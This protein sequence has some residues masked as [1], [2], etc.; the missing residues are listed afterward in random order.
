MA[1]PTEQPASS[2][3]W[4]RELR[5][6]IFRLERNQ[7]KTAA[8]RRA[9]T[10]ATGEVI[11]VQDADLEYDPAEIPLV[12]GPILDDHADVVYGSRFM[13]PKGVAGHL[14]LPLPG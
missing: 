12:V 1:Q 6:R 11:I 7:G 4:L 10:E 13:V 9:L 3:T 2:P 14:L 8:I 5:V